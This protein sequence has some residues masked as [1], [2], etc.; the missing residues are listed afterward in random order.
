MPIDPID[1]L[2]S[3]SKEEKDDSNHQVLV[4]LLQKII[5]LLSEDEVEKETVSIDNFDEVKAALRNELSSV[6]KSINS[7]PDNKDI[8][9]ELKSLKKSIE[10]IEFNPNINVAGSQ[11]TIPEIRIPDISIPDVHVPAPQVTVNTPEIQIPAP[12]VNVPA[13]IINV[14]EVDLSDITRAIDVNLNKLRTNS[15]K[16]PLAVRMSDGQNW[17][18]ELKE[19]NKNAAQTTQF[20]SDV[21][22]IRDSS[23]NRINPATE[24]S[25]VSATNTINSYLERVQKEVQDASNYLAN[26]AA[27]KGIASDI[28]VTLVSGTVTTVTTVT[29][30]STVTGITNFG[31]LAGY[32]QAVALMNNAAVASNINNVSIN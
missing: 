1:T 24:D 18:K 22:Y 3:S 26:I 15:E 17:V 23:G 8:V 27:A 29:T 13:P 7:I 16:R 30:V 9:K 19:L 31:G 28:R 2:Q 25:L 21:S 32:P 10:S 6:V 20:M 14:P 11:V 5:D 12:I 4:I